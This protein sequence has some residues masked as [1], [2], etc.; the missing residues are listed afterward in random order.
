MSDKHF[1]ESPVD[2]KTWDLYRDR[3]ACG[4][5]ATYHSLGRI[6]A[7]NHDYDEWYCQEHWELFGAEAWFHVIK[8]VLKGGGIN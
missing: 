3:E 7:L 4:K 8:P 1:C 2:P 5:P 6:E